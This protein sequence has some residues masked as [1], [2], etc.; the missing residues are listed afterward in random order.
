MS[1][2][3]LWLKIATAAATSLCSVGVAQ[4]DFVSVLRELIINYPHHTN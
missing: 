2:V 3:K 1:T 4:T